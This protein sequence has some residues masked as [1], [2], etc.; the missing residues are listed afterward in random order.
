MDSRVLCG[1][2]AGGAAKR[3]LLTRAT[4]QA[5]FSGTRSAR[6]PVFRYRKIYR[7]CGIDVELFLT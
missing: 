4:P 2:F 6:V 7:Y 3:F 1:V 5:H